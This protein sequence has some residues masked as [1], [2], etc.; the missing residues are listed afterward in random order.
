MA[1]CCGGRQFS[2]GGFSNASVALDVDAQGNVYLSG[3]AIKENQRP[4]IF[5]FSAQD[6]S[7]VTRFDSNGNQQ[8]FREIGSFFFDETYDIAV[9]N[10][11]NSYLT[12]WTQ[13]LEWSTSYL[14]H[15]QF[16]Y[17]TYLSHRLNYQQDFYLSPFC[18]DALDHLL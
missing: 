12:G 8:W 9:D 2:S 17:Y 13:A 15:Q 10:D 11:G 3:L 18:D 16:L 14:S 4:D 5:N 1:I 7:W 6:D